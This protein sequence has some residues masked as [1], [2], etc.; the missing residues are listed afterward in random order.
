MP[1][2]VILILYSLCVRGLQM[3]SMHPLKT[4]NGESATCDSSKSEFVV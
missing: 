2:T 1:I 4:L 3:R